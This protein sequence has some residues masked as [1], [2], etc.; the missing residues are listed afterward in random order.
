MKSPSA[1]VVS[2]LLGVITYDQDAPYNDSCPSYLSTKTVTGCVATAMAQVM[3]YY[4]WPIQGT[5]SHTYSSTTHSFN[6]TANFG[7]TT[8][9][10]ANME[11]S[12]S[13]SE[14]TAQKA[15]IAQLMYHA[16]VSVDMD[17]DTPANGGSGAYSE[18]AG[19]SFYNYFGYDAGVQTYYRNYFVES[20]WENLIKSELNAGRPILYGGQS[21]NGGHEFVCDGYDDNNMFHFNWGW[22]GASNGYFELSALTPGDQGIGAN[23]NGGF[24]WSQ[25][26][27]VGIQTPVSGSV[28]TYVMGVQSITPSATTIAKTGTVNLT[29]AKL[30]N[31]GLYTM[32]MDVKFGMYQGST[33]VGSIAGWTY[34]GL[35]SGYGFSSI[36]KNSVSFSSYPNGTYELKLLY[37]N[38]DGDYVPALVKSGGNGTI[39][40]T[41]TDTQVLLGV[42]ANSPT[43]ALTASPTTSA[44]LYQNKSGNFEVSIQNSGTGEYYAQIGVKLVNTSNSSITQQVVNSISQISAGETKTFNLADVITVTPGTYYVYVY[45]DASNVST[46]TSFPTS[47][48]GP[49]MYVPTVT[50]YAEPTAAISLSIVGTPSMPTSIQQGETFTLNSSVLNS[51]RIFDDGMLA[52]VFPAAGGSSVATFGYQSAIID[53]GAT[54][55]I[56]F[57]GALYL[58]AGS[59]KAAIYYY[60]SGWHQLSSTINFSVIEPI[61]A[62]AIDVTNQNGKFRLV[63]NPVANELK[64]ILPD[65]GET[66]TLFDIQGK[67][68][69]TLNVKGKSD[70]TMVVNNLSSGTYIIM[71]QTDSDRQALKVL[72]K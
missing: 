8:Y 2:P 11:K 4:Q 37:K 38:E 44:N 45:Y 63:S 58:D 30:Y 17:Y 18:N 48:M 15:A 28:N 71:L 20:D 33:L 67:Q 43:L 52:A 65:N 64:V 49:S 34:S 66:L 56:D 51:G 23:N 29:V 22:S 25:S 53:N 50:V 5:G 16:G 3:K 24:N 10:W 46:N 41:V 31:I 21:E 70:A 14:T 42:P 7:I 62:T 61:P 27:L 36:A 40:V 57:D 13:G 12:Y 9:D 35:P 68:L 39:N 59:Y 19:R 47:L 32:N 54:E 72:K 55:A 1:V 26:I 60:D 69:Q 6:L